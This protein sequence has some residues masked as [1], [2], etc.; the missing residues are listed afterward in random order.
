MGGYVRFLL[1]LCVLA[2]ALAACAPAAPE[3]TATPTQVPPT[4]AP[5]LAPTATLATIEVTLGPVI[6]VSNQFVIN[7]VDGYVYRVTASRVEMVSM[8]GEVLFIIGILPGTPDDNSERLIDAL[9]D[10]LGQFDLGEAGSAPMAQQQGVYQPFTSAKSGV[11]FDGAYALLP[12]D[13]GREF[14]ALGAGRNNS[15]NAWLA[16][17]QQAFRAALASANLEVDPS[18]TLHCSVS[19]AAAYGLS[20]QQPIKVG[21]ATL[22]ELN[23]NA[24]GRVRAYFNTL[25]GPEGEFIGYER[26]GSEDTGESIVDAYYVETLSSTTT[27]YVDMYNYEPL[28]APQG[29]MCEGDFPIGAP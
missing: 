1:T 4:A 25:R 24:T 9:Q 17:G 8:D 13:D 19:P 7:E 26:L 2:L 15:A 21:G 11:N 20:A 27:L 12:L 10:S 3:P 23:F 14:F 28:F 5:T 6:N 16:G 22:G 29:F 18:L